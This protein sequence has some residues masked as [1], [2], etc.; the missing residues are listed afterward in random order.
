MHPM[1]TPGTKGRPA[2]VLVVYHRAETFGGS[3]N[4]VLDVMSR[5]D[6]DRFCLTGALPGPGNSQD[7]I[8]RLGIPVHYLSERPGGRTPQ[9][10]AAVARAYMYLR[11]HRPALVYI[12]DYV[13]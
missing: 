12:A 3:F 5:V 8:G 13:T 9:Y 2:P 4:S 11:R 6:R 7:S 1:R 10:A